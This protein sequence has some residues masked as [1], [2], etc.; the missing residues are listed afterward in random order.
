ML[1]TEKCFKNSNRS[2]TCDFETFWK[3]IGYSLF[4]GHGLV[5]SHLSLSPGITYQV[6]A[7]TVWGGVTRQV[8]GHLRKR[9]TS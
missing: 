9:L 8:D 1:K 6:P 2:K 3:G 4:K 5:P 7:G